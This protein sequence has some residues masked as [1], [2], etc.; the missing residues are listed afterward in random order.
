[1]DKNSIKPRRSARIRTIGSVAGNIRIACAMLIA[2]AVMADSAAGR[3][4]AQSGEIWP[5][6]TKARYTLR[7]NGIEVGR[8]SVNSEISGKAYTLS[9][10]SKASVLFGTF[11]WTGTSQ[12][13]GTIDGGAP[14][15]SAFV[16][17]WKLNKKSGNTQIGFTNRAAT[18]IAITP[19]PKPKRDVV[20]LMPQHKA[21]AL[22]PM[23]A[24]LALTRADGRAPCERRVPIF[25]GKHRYDIVLS[26]KRMLRLASTSGRSGSENAH[27]CRITY[28]PVAGHR[29]NEDTKAYAGNRDAELVLRRIPGTD[30]LIP[31]SATIPT[32][33]GTG[34]MTAERIDVMTPGGKV[35]LGE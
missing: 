10:S 3:A 8:L 2:G 34:T 4:Q 19:P 12:V 33:W 27:V 35:S 6:A 21:G 32:S 22:D 13:Q 1:M 30:M 26:P 5:T 14:A 7:Y 16:F 31:F 25:D 20:P 9:G 18:D 11:S 17:D 24:I 23:S 29:N 15:P 28:E